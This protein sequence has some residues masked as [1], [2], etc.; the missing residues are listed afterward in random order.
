MYINNFTKNKKQKPA[1]IVDKSTQEDSAHKKRVE[2]IEF[3]KHVAERMQLTEDEKNIEVEVPGVGRYSADTLS[4]NIVDNIGRLLQA[5]ETGNWEQVEYSLSPDK[6]GATLLVKTKAL[7]QT[8]KANKMLEGENIDIDW[9]KYGRRHPKTIAGKV[10]SKLGQKLIPGIGAGLMGKDAYEKYKAGD[11]TGAMQSGLSALG[12]AT[13]L[14]LGVALDPAVSDLGK[15]GQF[16]MNNPDDALYEFMQYLDEVAGPENCW[17]GYK[18]DGTQPGTGKNKGKR[19]NKCVPK[20]SV[21]EQG[22]MEYEGE[23]PKQKT[24][25][26]GVIRQ[27]K[28]VYDIAKKPGGVGAEV[29]RQATDWFK[30]ILR[31]DQDASSSN[32]LP[33]IPKSNN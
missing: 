26:I 25:P 18:K 5:A 16:Y 27:G 21:K 3:F 4:A 12:Y 22:P 13:A 31:K 1:P 19:V 2:Q 32:R 14:P 24:K 6:M 29:Q 8:L 11:Y 9:S 23:P 30:N 20:K 17:P 15:V 10:V 33:T 28:T 7:V